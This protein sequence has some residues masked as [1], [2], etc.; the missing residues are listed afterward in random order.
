MTINVEDVDE[1]PIVTVSRTDGA[2]GAL[3]TGYKHN[4]PVENNP[5]F[6]LALDADDAELTGASN[7]T[8]V[9]WTLTGTD[10]DDF[11]IGN[12]DTTTAGVLT[13]KEA[14]DFEAPKDS[15][16]NNVYDVT[17]QT[18]DDGGN[19]VSNMVKVTVVNVG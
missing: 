7:R 4:E 15:N 8:L 18:T 13:F 5:A 14:P 10:A 6:E 11:N 1:A 9:K 12:D 19:T 3:E 16:R 2:T 17:V